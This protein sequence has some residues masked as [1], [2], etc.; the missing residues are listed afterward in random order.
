E[1]MHPSTANGILKLLEE[2]PDKTV[3]LLV[4]HDADK[5]LTTILSRTQKVK[6]PAFSDGEVEHY[7]IDKFQIDA[8]RARQL[9]H[10]AD[11]NLNEAQ[12]LLDQAEDDSHQRFRDWMRFCFTRDFAK[13]IEWA[14]Q[15]QKLNKISQLTLLRYALTMMREC[16]VSYFSPGSLQRLEGEELEFVRNFSKVMDPDKLEKITNKL[17]EGYYHVERNANPK[18]LFTDLS[19]QIAGIIRT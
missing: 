10:M 1:F 16:L 8:S 5:I 11:G 9:A 4:A 3:F 15:Y 17:N 12:K 14:E 13:M 19:L 7:L 6:I 2:P 18:I